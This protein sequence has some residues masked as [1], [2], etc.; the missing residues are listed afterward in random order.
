MHALNDPYERKKSLASV[1]VSPPFLRPGIVPHRGRK[2]G[3]IIIS[4]YA[5]FPLS[6]T[7]PDKLE[8]VRIPRAIFVLP[9]PPR[10]P[11]PPPRED[12]FSAS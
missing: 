10:P 11:P 9:L 3:G 6:I 7:I 4:R 1:Y 8:N 5:P 2:G 12:Y